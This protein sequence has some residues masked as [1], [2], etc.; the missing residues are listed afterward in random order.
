M[1]RGDAKTRDEGVIGDGFRDHDGRD[2][3]GIV[4]LL[5]NRRITENFWK[6]LCS[7]VFENNCL[8]NWRGE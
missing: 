5:Q 1:S 3:D 2:R 7:R 8:I 6:R 4:D